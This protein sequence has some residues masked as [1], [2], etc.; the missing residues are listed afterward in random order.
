MLHTSLGKQNHA[1]SSIS[2]IFLMQLLSRALKG[3]EEIASEFLFC[4]IPDILP[5]QICNRLFQ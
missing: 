2:R 3:A 4:M 1:E 5:T